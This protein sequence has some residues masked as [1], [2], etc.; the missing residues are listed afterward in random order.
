MR[1]DLKNTIKAHLDRETVATIL[2]FIGISITRD[3]KFANDPS[4]T[5]SK[6]CLIKDWGRTGFQ[7]DI[8]DFIMMEKEVS[9][10]QAVKF[11]AECI[12]VNDV[13]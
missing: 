11:V 1:R 2:S 8:F 13:A 4:F 9:F 10:P 6:N 5:I 12:G 3:F 7:G